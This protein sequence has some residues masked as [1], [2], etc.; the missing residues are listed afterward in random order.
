MDVHWSLR[1]AMV[2]NMAVA[3]IASGFNS[4]SHEISHVIDVFRIFLSFS[5]LVGCRMICQLFLYYHAL[6]HIF[7]L[8]CEPLHIICRCQVALCTG[9]L[10]HRDPAL[11]L[12]TRC[13]WALSGFLI[14]DVMKM[15]SEDT[16]SQMQ[17]PRGSCFMASQTCTNLQA[18]EHVVSVDTEMSCGCL[19]VSLRN[20]TE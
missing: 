11:T 18:R 4:W 16:C 15:I 5:I 7:N 2:H 19:L 13:E 12:A 10:L 17:L 14:I 20:L 1:G 6:V 3:W 9:G 8:N